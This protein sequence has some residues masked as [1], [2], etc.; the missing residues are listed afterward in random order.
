MKEHHDDP[1]KTDDLSMDQDKNLPSQDEAVKKGPTEKELNNDI[2]NIIGKRLAEKRVLAPPMHSDFAIRWS[3]IMSM[4]LPTEER[5][6]LIKK[7]PVP[8][9]CTFL[10]PPKLNVEVDRAIT[11]VARFRDKRILDKQ[12]KLAACLAAIGKTIQTLLNNEEH[13]DVPVLE[14]LS[15]SCRLVVDAM[16]DETAV[17]RSLISTR[18]S[19][20]S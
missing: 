20:G 17:R 1:K 13:L 15:D 11:D 9:N 7:Y 2:L 16:H 12:Q 14:N 10:D 19:E 18:Q 4:G 5:D 3:E 6:S 8:E